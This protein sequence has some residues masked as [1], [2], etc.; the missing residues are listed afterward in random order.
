VGDTCSKCGAPLKW[1]NLKMYNETR[2]LVN[3]TVRC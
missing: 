3:S 1:T 2:G